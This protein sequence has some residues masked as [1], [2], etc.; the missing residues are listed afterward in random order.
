MDKCINDHPW[1]FHSFILLFN[2]GFNGYY[3]I[4][5]VNKS[6]YFF[7]IMTNVL[8]SKGCSTIAHLARS[9]TRFILTT[10]LQCDGPRSLKII[11]WNSF[12]AVICKLLGARW[13]KGKKEIILL[14][15]FFPPLLYR[16]LSISTPPPPL[17]SLP[18]HF[19]Q[20]LSKLRWFIASLWNHDLRWW[21]K[22]V[23]L[24]HSCL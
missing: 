21:F 19:F 8:L 11:P 9:L 1:H 18:S 6:K 13:K 22:I 16:Y 4:K 23:S 7:A 20:T 5:I 2:C 17:P 12:M 14:F 24:Y 15:P 10:K 3:D